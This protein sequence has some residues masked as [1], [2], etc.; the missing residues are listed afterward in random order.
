M[1]LSRR[2]FSLVALAAFVSAGCAS[3]DDDQRL[4]AKLQGDLKPGTSLDQAE[5]LLKGQGATY[6]KRAAQECETMVRESRV[7]TQLQ[8]KGGPCVFGKLPVS[9]NW[10]GGHKDIIL[11]LVFDQ[12]GKLRDGSFEAIEG[13]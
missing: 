12:D 9:R 11:Q 1:L 3:N 10:Y 13:M 6:S 4:L 7:P 2:L 8:P 5:A